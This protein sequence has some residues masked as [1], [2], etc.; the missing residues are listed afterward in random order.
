MCRYVDLDARCRDGRV[1][2]RLAPSTW[3]LPRMVS[4]PSAFVAKV[5]RPEGAAG[6]VVP[7]RQLPIIGRAWGDTR[8]VR[9]TVGCSVVVVTMVASSLVSS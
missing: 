2:K 1:V 9:A 4:T 7:P 3:Q 6:T 5:A 8:R